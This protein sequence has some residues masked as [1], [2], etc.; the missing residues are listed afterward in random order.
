[1]PEVAQEP[2]QGQKG[3]KV[4]EVAEAAEEFVDKMMGIEENPRPE[5]TSVTENDG[6]EGS[7]GTT[8]NGSDA[9]R[10][11]MEE[12]KTKLIQLRKKIVC[13]LCSLLSASYS[14][15][16]TPMSISLLPP[17]GRLCKGQPCLPR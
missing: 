16:P 4:A 14:F 3:G 11:T 7:D 10:L 1:M 13:L 17:P 15:P 2:E 6:Q 5:E 8:A 12:R 9:P